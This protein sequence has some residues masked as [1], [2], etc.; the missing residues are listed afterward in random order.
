MRPDPGGVYSA[1]AAE[2][3]TRD[4]VAVPLCRFTEV[5]FS[6]Q[7]VEA[8]KPE[9]ASDTTSANPLTEVRVTGTVADCPLATVRL[10]WATDKRKSGALPL[11]TSVADVVCWSEPATPEMVN[12]SVAAGVDVEVATV[13]VELTEAESSVT[14]TGLSEQLAP[15]GSPEQVKSTI[16]AKPFCDITDTLY[17]A[18]APGATDTLAGEMLMPN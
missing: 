3:M 11:T 2:L 12:T 4:A 9:Q 10:F 15:G 8:G 14:V 7:V 17:R 5:G 1:V 13:R 18:A 16:P 6:E